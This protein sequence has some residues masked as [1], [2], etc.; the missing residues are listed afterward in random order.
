MTE[1]T[2]VPPSAE[3]GDRVAV[4][5]LGRTVGE[6]FN[7]A[8]DLGLERLERR[9]GVETEL[10][11]D[12]KNASTRPKKPEVRA[13]EVEKAFRCDEYSAV[14]A[15]SGGT[16][17]I[18]VLKHLDK[19]TIRD[20][21]K[22]FFGISDNT[23][24]QLFLWNLGIASHYGGQIL[25]DLSRI[26]LESSYTER[27]LKK[28]LMESS[29]GEIQAADSYADRFPDF[30]EP[31][32]MHKQ[33]SIDN[34]GYSWHNGAAQEITGRTWGGCLEIVRWW[35]EA[36]RFMPEPE[37]LDGKIL[38]LETSED[39]PSANYVRWFLR[40]MAERR[41]L[42]RFSAILVGRPKSEPSKNRDAD[43]QYYLGV[44]QSPEAKQYRRNQRQAIL[45]ALDNY[46]I[47]IPVVFDLDFGHT[48]PTCCMPVGGRLRL[49]TS[50]RTISH[51]D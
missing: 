3:E 46:G 24:L 5:A 28:A 49:D 23:D 17:Q 32:Q 14:V 39:R 11:G 36:D 26:K 22:R 31:E 45:K 27:Y 7:E 50:D 30:E 42:Q 35:L 19:R 6:R 44:E 18:R 2:T 37:R 9:L 43:S 15:A 47:D 51:L 33:P 13:E 8:F 10:V 41:L 20:N 48:A 25:P 21:P 38:L 4:V 34:S 1:Q 12:I 29:L 40:S 16:D